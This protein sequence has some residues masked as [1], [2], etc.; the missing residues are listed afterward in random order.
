MLNVIFLTLITSLAATILFNAAPRVHNPQSTL[1]LTALYLANEQFAQLESLAAAGEPL[2]TNFLGKP[3]DL[4]TENAG[5]GKP[6]EFKVTTEVSGSNPYEV[7]VT[8][9]LKEGGGNFEV[10][11]KR[12]IWVAE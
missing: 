12:T 3:E 8:V 9:T 10:K 4:I 11:A 1:R 6:T 2:Q 5:K 7:T